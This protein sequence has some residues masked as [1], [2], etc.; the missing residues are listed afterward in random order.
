MPIKPCPFAPGATSPRDLLAANLPGPTF[1]PV[2]RR[3]GL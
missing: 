2:L 1:S 3:R